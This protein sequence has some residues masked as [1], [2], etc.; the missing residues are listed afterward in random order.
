MHLVNSLVNSFIIVLLDRAQV[1]L[2]EME[3]V[4]LPEETD[5][6]G[7]V[8]TRSQHHEEVVNEKGFVV[9]VELEAPIIELYIGHLCDDIL[10]ERFL[11]CGGGVAHNGED[12]V[13]VFLVFVV[14]ED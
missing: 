4:G 11:P 8:Q 6:A 13:I 1:G 12:C 7:V 5:S 3:V 2:D 9:Q 10:E 14:E